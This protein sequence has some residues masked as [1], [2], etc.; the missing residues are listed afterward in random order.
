MLC[1]VNALVQRLR[2]IVI[3]HGN[4]LLA[5]DRASVHTGVHKMH[6]ASRD[7]DAVIQRLLP[8]FE[9]WK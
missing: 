5:D 9:S 1:L 4:G 7:F 3:M 8:C 2:R 6:G